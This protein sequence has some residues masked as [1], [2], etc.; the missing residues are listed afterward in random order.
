[1]QYDVNRFTDAPAVAD[2]ARDADRTTRLVAPE[3]R[4]G[5]DPRVLLTTFY[6]YNTDAARGALNAWRSWEFAPLSY[7]YLVVNDLRAAEPD[8]RA[9]GRAW[10][11][12]RRCSR[13]SGC[14]RCDPQDVPPERPSPGAGRARAPWDGCR[15]C[16]RTG[17]SSAGSDHPWHVVRA[18]ACVPP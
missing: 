13:S 8:A 14:G 5:L 11:C 3:L 6:Q 2:G 4:L 17:G 10:P 18:G 1:V 16:A 7:V 12:P 9:L 15:S